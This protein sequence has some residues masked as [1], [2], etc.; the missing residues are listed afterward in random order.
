MSR[1]DLAVSLGADPLRDGSD[2]RNMRKR[3]VK[4]KERR[5][6][7]ADHEFMQYLEKSEFPE[8]EEILQEVQERL[9]SKK[10]LVQLKQILKTS[11]WKMLELLLIEIKS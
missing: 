5:R 8:K 3:I 2:H 9:K 7:R 11:D 1:D 10:V 6:K 4:T